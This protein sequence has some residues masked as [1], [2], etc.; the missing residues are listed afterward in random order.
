[1]FGRHGK[2]LMRTSTAAVPHLILAMACVSRFWIAL[3]R[4]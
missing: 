1:M 2:G 4:L 3:M